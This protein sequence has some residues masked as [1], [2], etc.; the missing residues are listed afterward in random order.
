MAGRAGALSGALHLY[1]IT[2]DDGMRRA[3]DTIAARLLRNATDCTNGFAHGLVG[4]QHALLAWSQQTKTALPDDFIARIARPTDDEIIARLPPLAGTWCNGLTGFVFLWVKA[5]EVTGDDS[6]R[7]RARA[8]MRALFARPHAANGSLCC[9]LGGQA[10]AALAI[11]RID[12][13][14]DWR[15]RATDL[16]TRSLSTVPNHGVFKGLPGLVCLAADLTTPGEARF[17]LVE[18]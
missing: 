6:W 1:R 13:S 17:P 11:G 16:C 15:A 8:T 4:V 14:E 3:A 12:D 18:P 7:Q 2:G 9:G 5:Y 10:Y